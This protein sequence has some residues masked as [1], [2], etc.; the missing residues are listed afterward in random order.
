[1]R[2]MSFAVAAFAALSLG[3]LA[4]AT[5]TWNFA[6]PDGGAFVTQ[7]KSYGTSAGTISV[8][9]E[10]INNTTKVLQGSPQQIGGVN[11]LGSAGTA[12]FAVDTHPNNNGSGIGPYSTVQGGSTGSGFPS[13]DGITDT[14]HDASGGS[15]NTA[16]GNILEIQLGADI[17]NGAILNFLMQGV[18]GDTVTVYYGDFSTPQNLGS[19][20]VLSNPVTHLGSDVS[21]IGGISTTGTTSQF[22]IT[23][24]TASNEFVAIVADCHYLLLDTISTTGGTQSTPEPRFY[25]LLLVSLLAI[26]AIRRRF[27]PEQ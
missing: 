4:N 13:Q 5:V 2:R 20:S 18:A 19:L 1:M 16:Y 22:S 6:G 10:Q 25:G 11:T 15:A 26:P 9:A 23:K 21:P 17:A 3:S 24:N 27:V 14:L 8:F 12:L 7:G